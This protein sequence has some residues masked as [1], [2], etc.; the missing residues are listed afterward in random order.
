MVLDYGKEVVS[1]EVDLLAV[2]SEAFDLLKAA[3]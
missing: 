2:F 1:H 3:S